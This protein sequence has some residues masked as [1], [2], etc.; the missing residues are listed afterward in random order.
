MIKPGMAVAYDDSR[1]IADRQSIE[2]VEYLRV[3]RAL[4][5]PYERDQI[6]RLM[7]YKAHYRKRHLGLKRIRMRV[8]SM[9]VLGS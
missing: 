8:K 3:R 7:T 6:K 5:E 9:V 2:M 4:S 1:Q